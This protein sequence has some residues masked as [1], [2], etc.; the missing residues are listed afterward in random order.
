MT[1]KCMITSRLT[2]RM[3][4]SIWAPSLY[5]V[6]IEEEHYNKRDEDTDGRKISKTTCTRGGSGCLHCISS[7]CWVI[8]CSVIELRESKQKALA[9]SLNI[10]CWETSRHSGPDSI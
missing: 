5:L 8:V 1:S 9:T 6:V 4:G 2:N 10:C 3:L 7:N